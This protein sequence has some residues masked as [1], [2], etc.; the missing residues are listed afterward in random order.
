MKWLSSYVKQKNA[1]VRSC[2]SEHMI[3]GIVLLEA[4]PRTCVVQGLRVFRLAG[5]VAKGL[6]LVVRSGTIIGD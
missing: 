5:S 3:G 1:S 4:F 2:A 6:P